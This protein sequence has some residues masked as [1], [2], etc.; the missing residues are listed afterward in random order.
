MNESATTRSL[1]QCG[2]ARVEGH[3]I[4]CKAGHSLHALSDDGS[5]S[6]VRLERRDPL[7]LTVCQGCPDFDDIGPRVNKRQR[8]WVKC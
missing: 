5:I 2:N 7:V 4:Y 6:I 3:R 1:Y 8:G